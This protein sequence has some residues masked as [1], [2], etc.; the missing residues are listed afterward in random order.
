MSVKKEL[1][2]TE[3]KTTDQYIRQALTIL[4]K[5]KGV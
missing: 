4:A 2:E 3:G 5:R 1:S